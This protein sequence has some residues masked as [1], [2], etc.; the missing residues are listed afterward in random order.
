MSTTK[1]YWGAMGIASAVSV[2]IHS[3]CFSAVE[4]ESRS[5]SG[6]HWSGGRSPHPPVYSS[7]NHDTPFPTPTTTSI[8][9]ESETSPPTKKEPP[10]HRNTHHPFVLGILFTGI[11]K[12]NWVNIPRRKAALQELAWLGSATRSS[13]TQKDGWIFPDLTNLFTL[14]TPTM[15]YIIHGEWIVDYTGAYEEGLERRD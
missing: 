8:T 9:G 7:H 3:T 10:S 11:R 4:V 12:I 6:S 1:G 13:S 15:T 14:S 2:L 5:R